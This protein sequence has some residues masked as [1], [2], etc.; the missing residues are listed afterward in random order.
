MT[1]NT[2]SVATARGAYDYEVPFGNINI[3]IVT[4][5]LQQHD[6]KHIIKTQHYH[7]STEYCSHY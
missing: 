1:Y 2:V 4:V 3:T 7:V 6:P 5:D